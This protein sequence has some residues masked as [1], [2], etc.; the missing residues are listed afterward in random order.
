[1]LICHPDL[2]IATDKNT[3]PKILPTIIIPLIGS[4]KRARQGTS[5]VITSY[6]DPP[7]ETDRR[8]NNFVP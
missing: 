5:A 7:P 6:I 4:E 1:M 8:A 3:E 2:G